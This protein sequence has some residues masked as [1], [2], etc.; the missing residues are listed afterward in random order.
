ML[1]ALKQLLATVLIA[2]GVIKKDNELIQSLTDANNA[3]TETIAARDKTIQDLTDQ[4]ANAGVSAAQIQAARD[5]QAKAEA[6][7]QAARTALEE[8]NSQE[9]AADSAQ[10]ELAAALNAHPNTPSVDP[11]TLEQTEPGD[12]L[13]TA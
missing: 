13:P 2:V 6:D 12:P 4:L 9:G 10:A 11:V 7:S 1:Q 8:I 3:K 5:A